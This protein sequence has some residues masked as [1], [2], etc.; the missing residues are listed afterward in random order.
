MASTVGLQPADDGVT[1]SEPLLRHS[2]GDANFSLTLSATLST[3]VS[4]DVMQQSSA[5]ELGLDKV[6]PR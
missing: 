6:E 2:I 4:K 1:H 3:G 5:V